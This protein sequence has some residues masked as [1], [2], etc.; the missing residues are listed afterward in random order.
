MAKQ[1]SDNPLNAY[2]ALVEGNLALFYEYNLV[3][4]VE[5]AKIQAVIEAAVRKGVP[6]SELD[7]VQVFA[8][9]M[10]SDADGF[11]EIADNL[12]QLYNSTDPDATAKDVVG[13]TDCNSVNPLYV[14]II[15]S[16]CGS[17][18]TAIAR[19]FVMVL[20]I[21]CMMFGIEWVKRLIRTT[22]QDDDDDDFDGVGEAGYKSYRTHGRPNTQH[23][24][25]YHRSNGGDEAEMSP[26]QSAASLD[27]RYSAN[28]GAEMS[29]RQSSGSLVSRY[30]PGNRGRGEGTGTSY[31]EEVT[32][33]RTPYVW[34]LSQVV[35]C[36]FPFAGWFCV[37]VDRRWCSITAAPC[38]AKRGYRC[39][40]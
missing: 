26:R 6:R 12:G 19:M 14:R 2:Y 38:G 15:H 34:R 33:R 4:Y 31:P 30:S 18:H 8:D 27:S 21:A 28:D 16:F 39:D 11:A 7:E 13:Q 40:D 3:M 29:R 36:L 20:V 35:P 25:A 5:I 24:G 17:S 37:K 23:N 22:Q 10:T 9:G 32:D 1:I